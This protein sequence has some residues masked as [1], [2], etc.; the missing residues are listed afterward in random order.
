M[1]SL[2]NISSRKL[3]SALKK[4]GF[5]EISQKG[6]HIKMRR[7]TPRGIDTV[8]VPDHKVVSMGVIQSIL[9]MG[10]ISEREILKHI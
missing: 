6:S 10:N 4:L 5:V 9:E 7:I 8:I 3:L 2:R 1:T